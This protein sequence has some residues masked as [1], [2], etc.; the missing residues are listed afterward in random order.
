MHKY[1]IWIIY[2]YKYTFETFGVN[3]VYWFYFS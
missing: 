3:K 2:E 1:S